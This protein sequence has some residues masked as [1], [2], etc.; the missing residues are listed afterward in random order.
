[1]VGGSLSNIILGL[2]DSKVFSLDLTPKAA[3]FV[4]DNVAL[5]GCVNLGIQTAKASATTVNYGIG[6][7][8]R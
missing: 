3:W 4:K 1:M 7:L 6:G 5:G 2:D 8:G